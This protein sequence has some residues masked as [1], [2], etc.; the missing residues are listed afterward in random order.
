MPTPVPHPR[1]HHPAGGTHPAAALAPSILR[2]ALTERLIVVAVM[3]AAIW[4][5]VFW[6]M[7]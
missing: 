2:L 4:G 7:A 3:V 1:H 5:A 6:A